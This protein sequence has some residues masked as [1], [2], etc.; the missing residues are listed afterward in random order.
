MNYANIKPFQIRAF[1]DSNFSKMLQ[2]RR[3]FD[4]TFRLSQLKIFKLS[5]ATREL[6][7]PF[8]V[9]SLVLH[10]SKSPTF[11]EKL[12]PSRPEWISKHHTFQSQFTK[13][14]AIGNH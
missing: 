2:A 13:R 10:N 7:N 5:R 4:G 12:S 1:L 3:K 11:E 8:S 9:L 6:Q 14:A